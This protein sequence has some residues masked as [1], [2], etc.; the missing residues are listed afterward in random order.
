LGIF[1][2]K[3]QVAAMLKYTYLLLFLVC[4]TLHAQTDATLIEAYI[5]GLPAGKAKLVGVQGDRNYIIDSTVVD[6]QGHFTLKRSQ[7]LPEG[8][9][10]FILP[11]QKTLAML[12]DKDQT[13]V[14]RGKAADMAN[15]LEVSG[16]IDSELLYA[17]FKYQSGLDAEF[18]TLSETMQKYPAGTPESERAKARQDELVAARKKQLDESFAKYPNSFYTKFKIAGQNPEPIDFR[19]PNGDIDTLRR[20]LDYRNRFWD[21]V[22]FTDERLLRTPVIANKLKRYI[23][24]LTPQNPDSLIKVADPLIRRVIPHREYFKFFANWIGIY[25][26]NGRTTVMDGEAVYVHII[27]NFMKPELAYWSNPEEIAALQKHVSE[28]EASLMGRKGPDVRAMDMNGQY[29]SIYEMKAPIVVVFMYSPDC[30]HCQKDAPDIQRIYEKWKN[31]GVDF[32]GIGVN[33]TEE[34]LRP[35]I[36]KNGFTFSNVYDPTN[37]AIYAKYYVDITPEL[38][39]LNKDRIIVAKNLK[40]GQLEEIFEKELKKLR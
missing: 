36:K 27:K 23:T 31:K 11:A 28:M 13:F 4:G 19:K 12:I 9:Y 21:G 40:H 20:L 2:I 24:E 7:L 35:F 26:E 33:C 16:C 39:V 5:E 25:Y 1:A 6:A 37:R 18:K 38:Y 8:Y 17:N 15:T 29:K 30:E 10:Y 32:Y 3:K 34:E 14:L 22:D